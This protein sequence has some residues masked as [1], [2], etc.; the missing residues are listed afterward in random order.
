MSSNPSSS[1]W[2]RHHNDGDDMA[3]GEELSALVG[4]EATMHGRAWGE[5]GN[6][7]EFT[8]VPMV[9]LRGSGMRRR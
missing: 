9:L 3:G 5:R 2:I 1:A 6:D 7:D 8:A 4:N